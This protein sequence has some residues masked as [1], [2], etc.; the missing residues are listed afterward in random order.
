VRFSDALPRN[1]SGKLQHYL[2]R[3]LIEKENQA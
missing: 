3:Q 2:L 1:T